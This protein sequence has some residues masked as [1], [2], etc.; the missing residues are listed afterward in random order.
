MVT[1]LYCRRSINLLNVTVSQRWKEV[2]PSLKAK[3]DELAW[4]DK[5]RYTEEM[6]VWEARKEKESGDV[7]SCSEADSFF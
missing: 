7:T 1:H 5:L 4:I 2:D 6:K 3:L